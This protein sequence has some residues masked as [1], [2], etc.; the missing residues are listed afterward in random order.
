MRRI[1]LIDM[2]DM[3]CQQSSENPAMKRLSGKILFSFPGVE[4]R[5][6]FGLDFPENRRYNV[7][8]GMESFSLETRPS[9]QVSA[10]R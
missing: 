10:F 7:K 4:D 2:H 8:T 1:M 3:I 5:V 6:P 9:H